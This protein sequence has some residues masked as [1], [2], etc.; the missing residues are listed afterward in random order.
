MLFFLLFPFKVFSTEDSLDGISFKLDQIIEI[1]EIQ[2]A[3]IEI[4]IDI[5]KPILNVLQQEQTDTN[6]FFLKNDSL[7]GDSTVYVLI[8]TIKIDTLA[9][10]SK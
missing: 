7:F 5:I 8:D 4:D 9:N 2:E 1:L 3:E 10:G 6:P